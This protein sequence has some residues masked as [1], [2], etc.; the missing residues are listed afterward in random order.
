M[1]C[2]GK[3]MW[4]PR[5]GRTTPKLPVKD[6]ANRPYMCPLTHVDR[7]ANGRETHDGLANLHLGREAFQ[8]GATISHQLRLC[9]HLSSLCLCGEFRE[10][11]SSI[12][13]PDVTKR[14]ERAQN[15]HF[16]APSLSIR[17]H[18]FFLYR[19]TAFGEKT[20]CLAERIIICPTSPLLHLS[21]P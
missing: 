7:K 12:N 3:A 14:R 15:D 13:T 4:Y 16:R 1:T 21:A 10:K 2:T 6:K 17:V 19:A 5:G 20:S 8:Q 18:R 9:P 11:G